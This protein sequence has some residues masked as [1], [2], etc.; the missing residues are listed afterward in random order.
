MHILLSALPSF[1]TVLV[2]RICLFVIGDHFLMAYMCDQMGYYEEKFE[3]CHYWG[4]K[5]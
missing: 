1:L 5:G 3:L 2:G 4:L